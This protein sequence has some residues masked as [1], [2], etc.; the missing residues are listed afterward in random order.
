[1]SNPTESSSDN[2]PTKPQGDSALNPDTDGSC[3]RRIHGT[4][5]HIRA[6]AEEVWTTVKAKSAS[7]GAEPLASR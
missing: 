3:A 7:L 2:K 4:L 1:M 5:D 6:T